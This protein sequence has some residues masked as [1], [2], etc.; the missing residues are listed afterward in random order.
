MRATVVKLGVGAAL[1]WLLV[2]QGLPSF[3]QFGGN[4]RDPRD[5]TLRV[6]WPG[7]NTVAV[8]WFVSVSSAVN[9]IQE[10]SPIATGGVWHT[11]V[12][13]PGPGAYKVYLAAVPAAIPVHSQQ[14]DFKKSTV[15]TCTVTSV[16]GGVIKD[17]APA[18]VG[19]GCKITTMVVVHA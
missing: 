7:R 3:Q 17:V 4:Q 19:K 11:D 14:G 2:T 1:L 10:G 13:L 18:V 12:T 5:V 16:S 9:P 8:V 6:V 15:T